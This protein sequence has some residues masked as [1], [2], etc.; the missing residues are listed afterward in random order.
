M[1]KVRVFSHW[2]S[3]IEDFQVTDPYSLSLAADGA[4]TQVDAFLARV[5]TARP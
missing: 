4:R 1:Y 5:H 3:A 2:S